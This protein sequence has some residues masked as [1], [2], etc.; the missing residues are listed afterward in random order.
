MTC[1]EKSLEFDSNSEEYQG[2]KFIWKV[3]SSKQ[4]LTKYS[5]C[6]VCLLKGKD[7]IVRVMEL[8]AWVTKFLF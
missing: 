7:W 2:T 6:H 3:P 1:L 8:W 5:C 4:L